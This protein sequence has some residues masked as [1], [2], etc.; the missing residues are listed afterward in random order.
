MVLEELIFK[1]RL[2]AEGVSEGISAAKK[3][4][5]ELSAEK[6]RLQQ[7]IKMKLSAPEIVEMRNQLKALADEK[8]ALETE[9]VFGLD[10]S[11]VSAL[12]TEL[13]KLQAEKEALEKETEITTN[14][15]G[16]EQAKAK[17]SELEAKIAALGKEVKIQVNAEKEQAQVKINELQRQ[18]IEL[19]RGIKVQI[20]AS[21]VE[22]AKRQL[23][24]LEQQEQ[25]TAKQNKDLNTSFVQVGAAGTAAFWAIIKAIQSGTSAYAQFR[26]T[27]MGFEAGMRGI[28][29]SASAAQEALDTLSADKLMSTSDV[30]QGI[31]NLTAYGL[32]VEQAAVLMERLK[33]SATTNRQAHYSLSEAVKVTTEG[34]KNENSVN[35]DAVGVTK[36]L[37]KMIEDY[38]RSLG[39]TTEALTQAERAQAVYLGFMEETEA[40]AGQAA[41]Y[42]EQF[43]GSLAQ[44]AAAG[45]ELQIAFGE[46]TAPLVQ[47]FVT[48]LTEATKAVTDF[49][50]ENQTL[51]T[52]VVAAVTALS[53]F[54]I[55]TSII[56]LIQ[57]AHAAWVAFSIGFSATGVGLAI[58]GIAA[59]I[60][61]IATHMSKLAEE[62]K[63]FN[64][65]VERV[66]ALVEGVATGATLFAYEEE[67][68]NLKALMD[69]AEKAKTKYDALVNAYGE[70]AR[71]AFDLQ[72]ALTPLTDTLLTYG[73]VLESTLDPVQDYKNAMNALGEIYDA[74]DEKI[75][76]YQ[77][78]QAKLAAADERAA[79]YAAEQAAALEAMQQS[80]EAATDAAEGYVSSLSGAGSALDKVRSGEKLLLNEM[81]SLI[82]AY[83]ELTSEIARNG[84]GIFENA[85][86]LEALIM[87]SREARVQQLKDQIALTEGVM[88]Q[89]RARMSGYEAEM[90]ALMYWK[91]AALLDDLKARHAEDVAYMADSL[92][93]LE[94][95]KTSLAMLESDAANIPT[96]SGGGKDKV[97]TAAEIAREKYD[98]EYKAFQDQKALTEMTTEAE[99]DALEKMRAGYQNYAEIVMDID[100]QI[101]SLRRQQSEADLDRYLNDIQERA[102]ARAENVNFAGLI[103]ELTA[104]KAELMETLADYP[105]TL[106]AR[107]DQINEIQAGLLSQ[108]VDKLNKAQRAEFETVLQSL[109]D[110]AEYLRALNGARITGADGGESTF[111]FGAEDEIALIEAK[112][113]RVNDELAGIAEQFGGDLSQMADSE[114]N[115]YNSLLDKQASYIQ[116]SK[117]QSAKA[118]KERQKAA[119][120]AA[121][122]SARLLK[123]NQDALIKQE[124]KNL[125]DRKAAAKE[126]Y[127]YE[128]ERAKEAANA[129][130]AILQGK[131]RQIE[132]IMQSLDRSAEEEDF[133]DKIN[134]L[135]A[136]LDFET[137]DGNR[138]ELQKEIDN[139]TAERQKAL[140]R[141][142][143]EDEKATLQDQIAAVRDSASKRVDELQKERDA[144]IKAHEEAYEAYEKRIKGEEELQALDIAVKE[145]AVMESQSRMKKAAVEHSSTLV[146]TAQATATKSGSVMRQALDSALATY[147]AAISRFADIGRRQGAA[148]AE[149]FQAE[150]ARV[151]AAASAT[152]GSSGASSTTTSITNQFYTPVSSYSEVSKATEQMS[153]QLARV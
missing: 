149:A 117:V 58:A 144:A 85:D 111:T 97:K 81:Q 71:A 21:G 94:T 139:L 84:M 152:V 12:R 150:V 47:V 72:E 136:Q 50:R 39:K 104:K 34:I 30:A 106:K 23:E 16:V 42:V 134:R 93:Q 131:I 129:E 44:A 70:H 52:A 15:Q 130:I 101:Y 73:V 142:G 126:L 1:I 86:A 133:Q 38:A 26:D 88:Q 135:N 67:R 92:K 121:K 45:K 91:E 96:G 63:R 13:N 151:S 8:R 78:A 61:G 137:D 64:A 127:D 113:A 49:I 20:D 147:E 95:L 89:V 107:L 25:S 118:I 76:N 82:N 57:K 65:E 83:P 124:K 14:T 145:A 56:P 77:A 74:H 31:K 5:S 105:E 53:G 46:A 62:T 123:E 3:S 18:M 54:M 41:Q 138:Y 59:L 116:Q 35:A 40:V 19:E 68:G 99:L 148:Y 90:K 128:I 79:R 125:A 75:K 120:D 9:T 108:R 69:E 122:E 119:D 140:R 98:I 114:F 27:M 100:K 17:I 32:S 132:D 80:Y 112:L 28:G 6:D 43:G 24:A 115:Y 33:D 37:A 102:S 4:L 60:V 2:T 110:E 11:E 48:L 109:D 141:Q 7:E 103:N 55:L 29:V 87:A 143:L 66:K 153:I 51:V 146:S 22:E 10:S 36:N